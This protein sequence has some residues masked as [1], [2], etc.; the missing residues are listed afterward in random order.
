MGASG[1]AISTSALG[2]IPSDMTS[3]KSGANSEQLL[4]RSATYCEVCFWKC[5]AWA[6]SDENNNIKKIQ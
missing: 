3:N 2:A 4:K 6:Y 1:I 5:A